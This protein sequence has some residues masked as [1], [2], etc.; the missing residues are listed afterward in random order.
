MSISLAP[1]T[2]LQLL[3]PTIGSQTE[4]ATIVNAIA[5]R[6]TSAHSPST[7]PTTMFLVDWTLGDEI[8]ISVNNTLNQ[9]VSVSV[10]AGTFEGG[11][12]TDW[13]QIA[14]FANNP[15]TVSASSK[16][17]FSGDKGGAWA[18]VLFLVLTCSVAPTSGNL[19]ANIYL[20]E[21]G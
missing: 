18:P 15:F 20:K 11:I 9:S 5:I 2:V 17:S 7:D 8:F 19:T 3:S 1:K 6:D 12:L 14:G 13:G 21:M 16:A 10:H 4:K